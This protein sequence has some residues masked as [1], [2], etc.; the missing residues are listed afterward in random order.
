M[1]SH[2]PYQ[3]SVVFASLV[4]AAGFVLATQA[5]VKFRGTPFGRVLATLPPIMAIIALYHPI[6]IV[7][8]QYAAT[9]LLIES[10][11]FALLVV[12]AALAVRTHRRMSTRGA[13]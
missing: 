5:Y 3:L 11:G 7:F 12:F 13:G 10:G 2:P 6:L 9:A 4:G 1:T 8:P